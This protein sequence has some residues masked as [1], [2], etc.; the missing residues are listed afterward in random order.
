M[1]PKELEAA[2]PGLAVHEER[3]D[4]GNVH[5]HRIP[6]AQM[7][8]FQMVLITLVLGK[9]Y[10]YLQKTQE[11]NSTQP[12]PKPHVCSSQNLG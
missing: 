4:L 3:I 5:Y 9:I 7:D 2:L 1:V 10:K 11:R 8:V 6:F 12:K